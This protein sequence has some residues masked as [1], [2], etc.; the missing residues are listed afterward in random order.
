MQRKIKLY[1]ERHTNTNYLTQLITLNL[2]CV[3]IEGVVPRPIRTLEN[4]LGRQWL[5]DLYFARTR[6]RNLGW[7]HSA[8]RT[9]LPVQD[10]HF[11]TLTKNPYAWLL[12]MYRRPYH[13][14]YVNKPSLEEFLT[15]PWQTVGREN[16]AA[17]VDNPVA[18][19]NLKNRSYLSLPAERTLHLT[20]ESTFVNAAE[21]IER[22]SEAFDL[23]MRQDK[24]VDYERST[25]KRSGRDGDYY[26]DY[27][28][29]ERWR[30]E[31]SAEALAI[32]NA[33]LD[34]ELVAYYG[35]T[36]L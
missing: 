22:I 24:F 13:Q 8:V 27:Y 3:L 35:Y 34:S 21:V 17:T 30:S 20:S 1:G 28:L 26:R 11:L 12:S 31:L 23:P 14:H 18:L 32:I 9:D 29:N 15:L 6:A 2:D 33:G 5:R 19:W 25:K 10:A 16:L 4:L 36:L 7:K